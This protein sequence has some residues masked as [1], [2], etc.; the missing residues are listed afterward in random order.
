MIK[1][2]L[3]EYD[4]PANRVDFDLCGSDILVDGESFVCPECGGCHVVGKDVDAQTALI[5]ENGV[6]EHRGLPKDAAEKAA[7]L[8]EVLR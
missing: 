5:H 4:C 2:I 3:Q 6:W 1:E 7:W 8:A